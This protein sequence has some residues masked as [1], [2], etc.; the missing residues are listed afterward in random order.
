MVL[1]TPLNV[2]TCALGVL[3]PSCQELQAPDL[4]SSEV[5]LCPD[6]PGELR[7]MRLKKGQ[8]LNPT[9][10]MGSV[11]WPFHGGRLRLS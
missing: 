7:K 3:E 9:E 2:F 5:S 10:A 1:E 4:I 8:D 6:S 11:S